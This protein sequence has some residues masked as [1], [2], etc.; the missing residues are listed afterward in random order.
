MRTICDRILK[1]TLYPVGLLELY[2]QILHHR[3]VGVVDSP[4]EKELLLSGLVVKQQG[5]LKVHNRIYELI[6]D[7]KKIVGW[8]DVRKPNTNIYV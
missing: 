7:S 8:V 4:E 2:Q 6:F 1:N 3:Q 5:V